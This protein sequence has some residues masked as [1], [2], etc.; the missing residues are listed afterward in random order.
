MAGGCYRLA[1]SRLTFQATG[2]GSYLLY[3]PDRTF[4]AA[5][6][7]DG[8]EPGDRAVAAARTGR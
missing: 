3:A 5:S 7:T 4:L 1:G 8:A 2:L 6:G